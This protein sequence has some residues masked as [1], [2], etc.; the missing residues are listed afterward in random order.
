[1]RWLIR[2]VLTLGL[3]AVVLAGTLLLLPADR[4]TALAAR[5]F[6]AATGREL[7]V[8]GPVSPSIWPVVGLKTGPVSLANADWSDGGPMLRAEALAIGLDPAA[9]LSGDLVIRR[10]EL[11]APEVLIERAADGRI[12]WQVERLGDSD[13]G[14][15]APASQRRVTL[16]HAVIRDGTIRFV[17]HAS[18]GRH[19][20]AAV[21]L[22]LTLPDLG[23][24]LDLTL[25][26]D[27]NGQPLDL[28]ARL[29]GVSGALAGSVVPARVDLSFA[30]ARAQFDGRA[31]I[32]PT[33]EG[34]VEIA[35]DSPARAFAALG[36][37][38]PDL[39]PGPL[40]LAGQATWLPDGR[41]FLREL[42]LVLGPNRVTGALD[43][44]TAGA[45]P[46]LTADLAAGALDLRAVTGGNGGGDA[47]GSAGWSTA[48]IDAAAVELLD[49]EI[50]LA[51]SAINAGAVQLGPTRVVLRIDNARAVLD[52]REVQAYGGR[53]TGDLVLNN[54]SGLSVGGRLAAAGLSAQ[55]LL[56]DLAGYDRLIAPLDGQVEF[57]GVGNSVAAIISSLSG[58]GRVSLG[59]GQLQG[60]DI[61]GMLRTLDTSYMGE[62]A[63]TIFDSVGGTF[64]MQGGIL[65]N[66]DLALVAPIL[67]ASGRGSVDLGRRTLDYRLTPTALQAEDGSGGISVPLGIAAPVAPRAGHRLEG[68]ADMGLA[69]GLSRAA[70]AGRRTRNPA[71]PDRRSAICRSARSV[72]SA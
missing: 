14:A 20:L 67:R 47:R 63:R 23:G 69:I 2:I 45:R 72:P 40:S 58:Q 19:E 28:T 12:N 11:I 22:D 15:A 41:A 54:R 71:S 24:A 44:A 62:G 34:R 16:D 13:G 4:I 29:D 33:A 31:G 64:T 21:D 25:S 53:V 38:T 48:P 57:V 8:S 1:M 42:V 65:R 9:L 37:G 68:D 56:R 17:D 27:L 18:G 30:G 5:Q 52:L 59:Q 10:V 49:A 60:F 61:V 51:A 7:Q 36:L 70:P 26:A 3:L 39:P 35:A 6:A 43:L 46:R 32:A 55:P 50:A 66:E